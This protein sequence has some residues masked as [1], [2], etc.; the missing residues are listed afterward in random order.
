[1]SRKDRQT[2]P[3]LLD[4]CCGAGG[5]AKG[6]ADAGW[7]VVGVDINPQP[8]YPYEFIQDDALDVLRLVA[9]FPGRMGVDAIHASPPCQAYSRM[10]NCRP[11]VAAKYPRLIEP[12]RERLVATGL[13]YIIENVPGSPLLD[14]TLLC[15]SMFGREL[16]RHRLFETNFPLPILLHPEHAI[17]ASKAGH[18]TP[19]T[20]MS[21]AGHVTPV[22]KAK[23]IMGIDWMTREELVE[24]IPPAFTEWVGRA[25]IAHLNQEAAA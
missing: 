7:R 24:A 3:L 9:L 1:M 5:A 10:S 16:Y 2:A 11:E 23:E 6:Y 25:L 20:V 18:W 17:P 21:V 22:S 8:H 4:L 14:P 12:I 15:G 13:P 19:G